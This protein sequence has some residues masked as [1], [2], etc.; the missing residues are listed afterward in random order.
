M[1]ATSKP[2]LELSAVR[3]NLAQDRTVKY[4]CDSHQLFSPGGE[5]FE[6]FC[7]EPSSEA[8]RGNGIAWLLRRAGGGVEFVVATRFGQRRVETFGDLIAALDVVGAPSEF[9]L[10]EWPGMSVSPIA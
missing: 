5:V 8:S 10:A 9:S 1:I 3:Y 2:Y 6:S 7:V 4:S